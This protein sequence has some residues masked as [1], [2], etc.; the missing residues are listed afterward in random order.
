MVLTP[1]GLRAFGRTLRC[2]I[3]RGGISTRKREGDKA[4][5]VGAHRIIAT[6]YRPDRVAR[7]VLWALPILPRDLWSDDIGQPD[8]NRWVKAPYQHSHEA[9]R[10]SDRLYDIVLLTDWNWP[11]TVPGHGSAIFVHVWRKPR[12]PTE[13]CVALSLHDVLWLVQRITPQTRLLVPKN[14][15]CT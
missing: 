5:P 1:C 13:G 8:Y 10:R 2:S 7:P 9:L 12:H 4:T 11:H 6:L 15:A 14:G 3:G